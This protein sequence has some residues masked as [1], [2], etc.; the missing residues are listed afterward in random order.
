VGEHELVLGRLAEDAEVGGAAV[1]DEV[2]GPGRIAAVL[3]SLGVALL[4]LLDFARDT[5]DHQV[6]LQPYA[7]FL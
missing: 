7:R 1:R 6:A 3:R 2:P 4:G 5:G